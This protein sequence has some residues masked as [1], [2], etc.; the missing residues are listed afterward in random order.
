MFVK[1]SFIMIQLI[2]RLLKL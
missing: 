2:T 1:K